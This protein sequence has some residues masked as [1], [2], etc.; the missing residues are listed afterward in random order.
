VILATALVLEL[1]RHSLTGSHC[2]FR[3]YVDNVPTETYVTRPCGAAGF[4]LPAVLD[5]LKPVPPQ[6]IV[7]G[8]VL[9][10]EVVHEKPLE[11]FAYDYD[12]VTGVLVRRIP[13]FFHAKPARVFDPNPVAAINDP[14]LRDQHDSAAAVPER[15][16]EEVLLERTAES[17]P[18]RGT[19]ARLVDLQPPH[20]DPPLLEQSLRFN[21]EENGFEDVNAYFHI[22]RTQQHLQSLGY[23]G[24]RQVVPYAIDVDA[25]AASGADNSYF[26]PSGTRS[27]F[28]TLYYGEGGTDDAEDADLVVH[29]YGHAILEWISPGTFSGP[30]AGQARALSE[31]F[32]DYLAF[33]A[34]VAQRIASGRDRYCFAD[35]DARCWPDDQT[36]QCGYRENADCLRR[37]DSPLTMSDYDP[38][39]I[40]GVEHRNGSIWS[41]AL[42][43]LHEKIGRPAADTIVIESLFEAPPNPTFAVMAQRMIAADQL[44]YRGVHA[45]AICAVMSARRIIVDCDPRPRFEL[46]HIQ[47][48]ERG[49]PI[50]EN[51]SAGV[52]STLTVTDTRSIEAIGVRVDIAHPSRGD[53][54]IELVPPD[55]VPIILQQ[56]SFESGADVHTTFGITAQPF[57]SLDHLRGRSAAGVWKLIVRDLRVRDAGTL[58]SWGLV[59]Q[60]TGA[61]SVQERP[62]HGPAQMIPVVTHVFGANATP[63]VSDVRIANVQATAQRATLL[64]TR[65][66]D[67]GTRDFAAMDVA[68][69][70]GQTVAFNDAVESLFHTSGSGSLEVLG[71]VLVMSRTY[72]RTA[73]GTLGQQVPPHRDSTGLNTSP[74]ALNPLPVPNTRYNAGITEI[75]GGRGVVR[76]GEQR[77]EIAP[78]SH[79]QFPWSDAFERVEVVTGD[80]RVVA[81]VSQVDNATE[82]AMYIPADRLTRESQ[83]RIAPAIRLGP[84]TTDFWLRGATVRQILFDLLAPNQT[85]AALVLT[86]PPNT[87]AATRVRNGGVSQFVPMLDLKESAAT[88]QLLFIDTVPPYRTNIGIVSDAPAFAEVIVH[89]S[90][91]TEVLR[92]TLG[93]NAGVAQT[94]VTPRLTNGRAVVRFLAGRGRAYASL[95]DGRTGDATFVPGQ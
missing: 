87:V 27:G 92:T 26:I 38:R 6:F 94:A 85:L 28:G 93:T 9:R 32:G 81:Y 8:R 76:I 56:V 75:S 47:S 71:D 14:G 78:F 40:A 48:D 83:T 18:L 29:E 54:R 24:Q 61:L 33:S 45:A 7:N 88:Q 46:T 52:T 84:W 36:Q 70:P 17:G 89:D 74:I 57:Q 62:R 13:L 37:L 1:A 80:A 15:A 12:A 90:A 3:E 5:G 21:R 31:G 77:I 50:P 44:L 19:H 67:D 10:R 2:R 20:I 42:R 58:L 39:E 34:H 82:D 69:A 23:V 66:G 35:W 91:G 95:V 51:N 43:E 65:S 4:S 79:L 73:Q 55:G 22:D 60:Y 68:L 64:F 11:P 49:L 59:I 30:F 63:F 53:L 16:Y 86:L 41:S 72:A 25:H